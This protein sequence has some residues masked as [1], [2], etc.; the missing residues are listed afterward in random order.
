MKR[1]TALI[2]ILLLLAGCTPKAPDNTTA[3]TESA[4]TGTTTPPLPDQ[5]QIPWVEAKGTPWDE[6]GALT[7]VSLD[8]PNGL[9]YTY[10]TEFDGDLLL[11]SFD[12]HLEGHETIELCLVELDDGT[13]LARQ[14]YP[15][16]L[17]VAPQVLNDSL[18]LSDPETG[19]ILELDKS[20]QLVNSW[21]TE[22][23]E[24]D[25]IMS[26]SGILYVGSWEEPPYAIDL[27]TGE[28]QSILPAEEVSY[29]LSNGDTATVEYYQA[30]SGILSYALL[31]L[32]T[33]EITQPPVTTGDPSISRQDGT[34]LM[35]RYNDGFTW[36]I[37]DEEGTR[38]AELGDE[39][40][41]LLTGDV[42]L[43][44]N[45]F[46]TE[47]TLLQT[48]GTA[49]A[50]CQ[51][52]DPENG[53]SVQF[54]TYN[55]TLDGWFCLVRDFDGAM[56]LLFWD[57]EQGSRGEDLA[58]AP[59]P[60]PDAQEEAL[61]NRAAEISGQYG[62]Y[63][64]VGTDCDTQFIDFYTEHATEY[65]A[66][67]M[68]LDILEDAF[69][70]Y[71]DGFFQQLRY[72]E[73]RRL[74]IQLVGPLRAVDSTSYPGTYSGFAQEME[75][76]SLIVMDVNQMMESTIHHE[77][78]HLIDSYLQWDAWQRD[79]ALFSETG[80]EEN[81]PAWFDGYTWNYGME[82]DQH[83]YDSFFDGY[84][85]TFPTED[86]ARVFENAFEEYNLFEYRDVLL[87]KLSYYSLCIRDAFD[88]TGWP[89][90]TYWERYLQN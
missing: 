5:P 3:G 9:Q 88:T 38:F 59:M 61:Q 47:L 89:E 19:K 41:Q 77:I 64:R 16:T 83:D 52:D 42:L 29:I 54:V 63:I 43:H 62:V 40:L 20:L 22:P 4:P 55:E 74:E 82:A 60:E 87:N 76:H 8:V 44:T 45:E 57:T 56:R 34:W 27:N 35:R 13:V 46:G 79:D 10:G 25:A 21:Q 90:I 17:C 78:S 37:S 68:A 31:D 30:G 50:T 18:Y 69:E 70:K 33:G 84:S 71:P 48:D 51:L 23:F 66:V 32:E 58:F 65:T 67:A 75:D 36:Y 6:E 49:L 1:M 81:N 7:E 26:R 86:R 72:G 85:T 15:M 2:L 14:E 80:W 28:R 39:F 53:L 12:L 11:Y 24:G 73:I